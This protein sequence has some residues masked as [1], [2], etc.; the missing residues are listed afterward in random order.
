[1][2]VVSGLVGYI[3]LYL[4]VEDRWDTGYGSLLGTKL[5]DSDVKRYAGLEGLYL[6]GLMILSRSVHLWQWFLICFVTLVTPFL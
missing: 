2:P 1:M 5:L 3:G 4:N 6:E